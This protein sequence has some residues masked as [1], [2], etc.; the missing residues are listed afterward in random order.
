LEADG[1]KKYAG[2][3]REIQELGIGWVHPVQKLPRSSSQRFREE[4]EGRISR[5][6]LANFSQRKRICNERVVR[7]NP[8][9]GTEQFWA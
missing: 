2:R 4:E 1:L 6:N 8:S 9:L 7:G 5:E 3:G